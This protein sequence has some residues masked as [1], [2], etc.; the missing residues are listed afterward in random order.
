MRTTI[1]RRQ[2]RTS[3]KRSYAPSSADSVVR[4]GLAVSRQVLFLVVL[5]FV[6]DGVDCIVTHAGMVPTIAYRSLKLSIS[7]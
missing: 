2:A 6:V 7:S 4:E 5:V 1:W 3:T